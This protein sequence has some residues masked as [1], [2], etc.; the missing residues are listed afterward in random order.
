MYHI[1]SVRTIIHKA[2][3]F[4]FV[5]LPGQHAAFRAVFVPLPFCVFEYIEILDMFYPVDQLI[6][7]DSP[8]IVP[9]NLVIYNPVWGNKLPLYTGSR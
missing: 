6:L 2:I 5:F 8:I 3:G 9:V 7:G 1:H 4:L